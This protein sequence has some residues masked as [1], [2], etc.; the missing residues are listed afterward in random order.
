MAARRLP[1]ISRAQ[2]RDEVSRGRQWVIVDNAVIDVTALLDEKSGHKGGK[3]FSIGADNTFLFHEL[4]ANLPKMQSKHRPDLPSITA[5]IQEKVQANIVGIVEG[6]QNE[7]PLSDP[8][9]RFWTPSQRKPP[10]LEQISTSLEA[11]GV[12][13]AKAV[14]A[15]TA[16]LEPGTPASRAF[17]AVVGCLVADAAAQPT[18]WN[19]KVTYYQDALRRANRWE[20]PEFI[21]PSMNAYYRVPCGS[22]SAYGDQ[23]AV[24]LASLVA[25]GGRVDAA[26]LIKAHVEKFGPHG[27]YGRLGRHDGIGAGDLPIE[28]PWRHGSIDKFLRSVAAGKPN[29][30]SRDGSSDC[31]VK[32]VPVAAAFAG[33]KDMLDRVADVVRITQNNATTVAYAQVAALVLERII[34]E[35]ASGAEAVKATARALG[36]RGEGFIGEE[37][38]EAAA[39]AAELSYL[40]GVIAFCGGQYNAVTVS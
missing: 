7:V 5:H 8:S 39:L 36:K 31:F 11:T 32:T 24:V 3:V 1:T 38:E 25:C 27:D 28:G 30:P 35:G 12:D 18:H 21:T 33:Q 15:A 23:A 10:Y 26:S 40:E 19:Y 37:L 20:S 9:H 29:A 22:Y 16:G 34:L 6:R 4:H 14:A 2:F 17:W 13:A